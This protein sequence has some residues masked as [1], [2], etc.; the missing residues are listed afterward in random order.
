MKIFLLENETDLSKA[1]CR[2][3]EKN[4]F[5]VTSTNSGYDAMTY[6]IN[7]QF[8]LYV[9]DTNAQGFSYLEVL[10]QIR[11]IKKCNSP[12]LIISDI[13]N[14]EDISKAYDFGCNDYIKKPFELEELLLHI[15]YHVKTTYKHDTDNKIELKDGFVFDLKEQALYCNSNEVILT[16]KERLLLTL[17]INYIGKTVTFEMIHEYVWNNK[18]MEPVS[19]RSMVHKLQKKLNSNIITNIRAV[20]YKLSLR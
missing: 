11:T 6:I 15:N 20:G 19:M 10:K 16:T 8:D 18:E 3:L 1:I 4:N 14:I 17:L 9:L 7:S 2:M 12:V 13:L 5:F